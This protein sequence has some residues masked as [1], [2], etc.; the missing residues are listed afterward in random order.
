VLAVSC[1]EQWFFLPSLWVESGEA[2]SLHFDPAHLFGDVGPSFLF[3]QG[4]G[5]QL[6]PVVWHVVEHVEEHADGELFD[7]RVGQVLWLAHLVALRNAE[8]VLEA[9][10]VVDFLLRVEHVSGDGGL[11]FG[12]L[13]F[14]W[15]GGETRRVGAF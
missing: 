1:S 14:R 6:C 4:C 10:A 9:V 11:W 2:V 12:G 15:E 8:L 3:E 5:A 13:S 7:L